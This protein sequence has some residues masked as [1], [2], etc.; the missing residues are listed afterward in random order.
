[1]KTFVL[2]MNVC[3]L[4][5]FQRPFHWVKPHNC[6]VY[7]TSL[8]TFRSENYIWLVVENYSQLL[9][10]KNVCS[11]NGVGILKYILYIG[12]WLRQYL[13]YIFRSVFT[14]FIKNLSE[15]SPYILINTRIQ[16]TQK[17]YFLL[18]QSIW[19]AVSFQNLLIGCNRFKFSSEIILITDSLLFSFLSL[20]LN[21]QPVF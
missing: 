13:L 6:F 15:N 4:L 5:F 12:Q 7:V 1:M 8:H 11:P 19:C 20:T 10:I 16:T 2:E 3:P 21:Q 17:M 14:K 18:F 9:C